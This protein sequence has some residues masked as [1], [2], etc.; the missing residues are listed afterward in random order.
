MV[1]YAKLIFNCDSLPS[2][3]EQTLGFYRRWLIIYFD[4]IIPEK[5]QDKQLAKKIIES[6]LSGVFN[7]VLEG[8]ER[9]LEQ[10]NACQH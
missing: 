2:E 7:W 8:L 6:E 4:Q 5:E 9:L 10:K 3:V 1:N